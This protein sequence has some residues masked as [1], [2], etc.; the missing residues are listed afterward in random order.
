MAPA[1]VTLRALLAEALFAQGKFDE[2]VIE[3][4]I[5]LKSHPYDVGVLTQVGIASVTMGHLNDAIAAFRQAAEAD[6]HSADAQRNLANA[7]FDHE[8][9]SE[10]A[11]HAER[12]LALRPSDPI[13][14]E[15]LQQARTRVP[16]ANPPR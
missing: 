3:Y 14:R 10:A 4:K 12:V 15:V 8:D 16:R 6:P 1:D 2:A 13:A 7:L 9:F 11:L 5:Y